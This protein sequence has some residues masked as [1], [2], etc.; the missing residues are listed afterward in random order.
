MMPPKTRPRPRPMR[1]AR[2]SALVLV[3]VLAAGCA[4]DGGRQAAVVPPAPALL[5]DSLSFTV[6]AG[7]NGNRPVRMSLVQVR[8][9]R[10][11]SELMQ[12]ETTAWFGAGGEAFRRAHPDAFYD[13]WELV[14]GRL[15]GPFGVAVDALVAGVLFCST[16]AGSPPLRVEWDGDVTV[17]IDDNDCTFSGGRPSRGP[18]ILN[19][20]EWFKRLSWQDQPAETLVKRS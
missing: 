19:P 15:A 12:I 18:S 6:E 8:D 20:L 13:D 9:A 11:V 17:R 14:P 10:L 3:V 5:L 7:V 4:G 2:C 1:G 16:R